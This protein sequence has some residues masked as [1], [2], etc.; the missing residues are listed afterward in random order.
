MGEI[1]E[2]LNPSEPLLSP[3]RG[4]PARGRPPH[5]F[6]A[7]NTASSRPSPEFTQKPPFLKTLRSASSSIRTSNE[8]VHEPSSKRRHSCRRE[9]SNPSPETTNGFG[10]PTCATTASNLRDQSTPSIHAPTRVGT[11]TK[12]LGLTTTLTSN[13]CK[14]DEP[15]LPRPS[16]KKVPPVSPTCGA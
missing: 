9:L 7:M 11:T 6:T 3:F 16:T 8:H 2:F 15:F 14:V 10:V 5:H 13:R 12:P 4:P 1:E